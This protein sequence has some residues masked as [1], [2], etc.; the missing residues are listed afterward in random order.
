M[1][2]DLPGFA[3]PV[4]GA[5]AGFRAVLDALSRP[6]RIRPAGAGLTPPA[7]LEQ[8]A[9][10]LLLTLT[11]A[12]TP[13]WLDPAAAPARD[14]IGF[15]CGAPFV[16][17]PAQAAFVLA[18]SMPDLARLQAGTD[19]SPERGATVILQVEGFDGGRA[20]SLAGPGLPAPA[21]LAVAGLPPGFAAAW[22]DNRA[23]FPRGIDLI[24]CAGDRLAALPRSVTVREG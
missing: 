11:D 16:E 24:L 15:H 18:L 17:D 20:F 5:Q 22:A 12:E 14:W 4:L 23:R 8:A 21:R 13:L 2:L 19:E 1:S 7:P 3:D 10:A 9:A 6:G